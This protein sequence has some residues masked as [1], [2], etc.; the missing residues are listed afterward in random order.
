MSEPTRAAWDLMTKAVELCIHHVDSGGPP[1]VG[2]LLHSDGQVSAP[3]VNLVLETGD[4]TAHA[5]ITAIR[6]AVR[7]H[8]PARVRG[9]VLLATGEP[10]GM[11][12]RFAA[13]HGI[14]EVHYAVGRDT[15]A[16]WGFDYR[17]GYPS[18][19]TEPL[20]L[21]RDAR[22]LP[23]RRALVP[24]TRYRALHHPASI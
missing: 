16:A 11:C 4:P 22:Q 19:G 23:V 21:E 6:Q 3:G 18:G 5:E 2:Q 24:F 15:A 20:S 13:A 14:A 10:C 1:F 9:A 7:E 8:G 17:S 12:Y